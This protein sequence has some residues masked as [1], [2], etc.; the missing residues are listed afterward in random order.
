MVVGLLLAIVGGAIGI[1][2]HPVTYRIVNKEVVAH[3]L[4]GDSS[5]SNQIDFLQMEND[6]NLY[7]FNASNFS[8]TIG[9][10]S[11]GD[12]SSVSFI[13]KTDSTTYIDITSKNTST[14]LVGD[15]YTLEQITVLD[16][17]GQKQTT[18]S[19][20]EYTQH[21]KGFYQL[22]WLIG[23]PPIGQ[24]N[25]PIGGGLIALGL[26]IAILALMIPLLRSRK[27]PPVPL[28]TGTSTLTN[29]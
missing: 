18:F 27:T 4:V 16:N 1:F 10:K 13:Y 19:S 28:E 6:N 7:I 2:S 9:S 8:P 5:S 26:V 15:A 24:N 17:K 23:P 20:S 21:P 29:S 14:H 12:G 3:L 22:F 11:F 25:W